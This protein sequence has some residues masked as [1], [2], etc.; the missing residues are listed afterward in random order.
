MGGVPH[1][2]SRRGANVCHWKVAWRVIL[3]QRPVIL[4]KETAHAFVCPCLYFVLVVS[5]F[6]GKFF[7]K[8]P[9]LAWPIQ[10]KK[11]TCLPL[12]GETR[13]FSGHSHW[14]QGMSQGDAGPCSPG[15][16]HSPLPT[17][18]P[19]PPKAA[20]KLGSW[21]GSPKQFFNPD[22]ASLRSPREVPA[23]GRG[24]CPS[25]SGLP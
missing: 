19:P 24:Q 4:G 5:C 13:V 10:G 7:V 20:G 21:T 8:A 15:H 12:G 1:P 6:L 14:A 25:L 2:S 23:S 18:F 9:S 17:C 16:F 11:K 22:K 3:G